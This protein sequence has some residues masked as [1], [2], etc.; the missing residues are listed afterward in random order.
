LG[1]VQA[2]GQIAA[3]NASSG[4]MAVVAVGLACRPS[5]VAVVSP[6]HLLVCCDQVIEEVL[7]ASSG[8]QPN[9]PLLQSIGFIPFDW[10]TP[11]GLG[12][13]TAHDPNY[14]YQVSK[15]PFGGTLPV[16]VN[17]LRAGLDGASYYQVRVDG[18]LRTDQFHTAKWE[19]TKYAPATFGTQAVKGNPGFYPVPSVSDLMLYM[20]PLPGCYLDS[21]N[22]T[23]AQLHTITVDFFDVNGA[24]KESATP[25]KIF[26]DNNP[27]SVSLS[28][29]AIG[30][31]S[32]TTGCGYLQYNPANKLTDHVTIA[33]A[34]GHPEGFATW[35]FSLTKAGSQISGVGGAV[36]SGA[37]F[38]DTVSNLLGCTVAAF[39]A[40]V[41][42]WATANTGWGRC[43]QY[44]RSAGEAFALAP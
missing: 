23:S 8:L 34:A 3:I 5:S 30:S 22:L 12:D 14:F 2:R 35:A 24:P 13:T 29:A 16:M 10:I 19:G 41:Y 40:G 31:N 1:I 11:G 21:T 9:G 36:P 38:D 20:Q 17:F 15:V 7:L 26:V 6:G 33:Y 25:L 28:M 4:G 18:N 42:V 32:A 43:S 39:A 37:Q 44:D 27:C